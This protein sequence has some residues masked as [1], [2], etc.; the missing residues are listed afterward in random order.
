[1]SRFRQLGWQET[2][3]GFDQRLVADGLNPLNHGAGRRQHL[4]GHAIWAVINHDQFDGTGREA[5]Q[6]QVPERIQ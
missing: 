4:A 5:I 2:C 3:A 1:M 6:P